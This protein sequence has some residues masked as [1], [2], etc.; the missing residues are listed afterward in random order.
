MKD[1]DEVNT[2]EN[3]G[4]NLDPDAVLIEDPISKLLGSHKVRGNPFEIYALIV[5]RVPNGSL[6]CRFIDIF[7]PFDNDFGCSIKPGRPCP[8]CSNKRPTWCPKM[9]L[10]QYLKNHCSLTIKGY[11]RLKN[12]GM[13]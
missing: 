7:Q 8:A 13:K 5:K 6:G 3:P 1:F 10:Q 9:T 2:A 12:G 11:R 4:P